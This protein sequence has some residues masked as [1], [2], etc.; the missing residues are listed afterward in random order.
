MK[1]TVY[2]RGNKICASTWR[3]PMNELQDANMVE[4][5]EEVLGGQFWTRLDEMIEDIE[6]Y[7]YHVTAANDEYIVVENDTYDEES[8]VILYLGHANDTI[9]IERVRGE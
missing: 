4:W 9:W 5:F 3:D 2:P 1:Y 8:E 6:E 7:G